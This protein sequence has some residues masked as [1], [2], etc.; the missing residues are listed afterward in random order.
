MDGLH[1]IGNNNKNKN[2]TIVCRNN[3]HNMEQIVCRNIQKP[4]TNDVK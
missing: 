1:N 2:R 3:K 4:Q